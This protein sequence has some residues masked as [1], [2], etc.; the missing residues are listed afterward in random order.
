M[1]AML[2]FQLVALKVQRDFNEIDD[3]GSVSLLATVARTYAFSHFHSSSIRRRGKGMGRKLNFPLLCSSSS[4]SC[5]S[6]FSPFR[7]R[8]TRLQKAETRAA[9]WNNV[10][11]LKGE[12]A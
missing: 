5:Y 3:K 4:R 1:I 8:D 10:G 9:F 2:Y 11:T 12:G 6:R 7:V